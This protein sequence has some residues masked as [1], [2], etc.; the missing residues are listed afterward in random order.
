MIDFLVMTNIVSGKAYPKYQM[1]IESVLILVES[2]LPLI[3]IKASN[4]NFSS[5]IYEIIIN[6]MNQWSKFGK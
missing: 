4:S 1:W 5:F 3:I 6:S 2:S